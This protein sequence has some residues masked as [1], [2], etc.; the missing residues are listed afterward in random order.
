MFLLYLRAVVEAASFHRQ[1]T[2]VVVCSATQIQRTVVILSGKPVFAVDTELDERARAYREMY[3]ARAGCF[4]PPP[5]A[6]IRWA[7][8][9]VLNQMLFSY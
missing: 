1:R 6:T 2:L 8:V 5:L 3:P 4:A 7:S 9:S